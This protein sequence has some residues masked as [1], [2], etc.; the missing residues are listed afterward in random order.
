MAK[1][2]SAAELGIPTD[3]TCNELNKEKVLVSAIR[4][5]FG[6]VVEQA[7]DQEIQLHDCL[8]SF[9]YPWNKRQVYN[10]FNRTIFSQKKSAED[11]Y[12]HPHNGIELHYTPAHNER[13]TGNGRVEIVGFC[14]MESGYYRDRDKLKGFM[15][16]EWR[17][18][19]VEH[20]E[21]SL[22]HYV[23]A[24][25]P[26]LNA[27]DD[28]EAA[29]LLPDAFNVEILAFF[30]YCKRMKEE[31]DAAKE[32][33]KRVLVQYRSWPKLCNDA[34]VFVPWVLEAATLNDGFKKCCDLP[35]ADDLSQVMKL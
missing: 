12:E 26:K 21:L 31:I 10:K 13:L 19:S 15:G 34:D 32:K 1:R 17:L 23:Y 22:S 27:Y 8:Y 2:K 4:D 5:K 24:P 7:I 28:S 16:K 3:F 25:I 29:E 18:Y 30:D 14:S 20:H 35:S 9:L 11:F 33:I 6:K